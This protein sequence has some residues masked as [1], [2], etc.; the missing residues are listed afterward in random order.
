MKNFNYDDKINFLEVL[1][2]YPDNAL[3]S[4]RKYGGLVIE[5]IIEDL[6]RLIDLDWSDE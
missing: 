2:D 5:E 3:I 4:L 6:H 1:R